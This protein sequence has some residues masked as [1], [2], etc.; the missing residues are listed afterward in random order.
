MGWENNFLTLSNISETV[1]KCQLFW[2]AV[3]KYNIWSCLLFNQAKQ[4]VKE[5][6]KSS[7]IK[8]KTALDFKHTIP[9]VAGKSAHT[10]EHRLTAKD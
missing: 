7:R 1:K 10:K 8:W 3:Q 2:W 9:K 4:S 6:Q 5:K